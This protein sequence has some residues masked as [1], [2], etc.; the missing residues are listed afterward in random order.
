MMNQSPNSETQFEWSADVK[1]DKAANKKLLPSFALVILI[2]LVEMFILPLGKY[3]ETPFAWLVSEW[4]AGGEDQLLAGFL[5]L[6]LIFLA[7][8]LIYALYV[9]IKGSVSTTSQRNLISPSGLTIIHGHKTKFYPWSE[10]AGFHQ[11]A[12]YGGAVFIFYKPFIRQLS[13]PVSL[14]VRASNSESKQISSAL[15]IYLRESENYWP[16]GVGFFTY[17]FIILF[18]YLGY[19]IYSL[20]G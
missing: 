16:T 2:P 9:L 5:F 3:Q 20:M 6:T 13:S 12:W 11:S 7:V 10:F 14:A 17:F 4:S 1:D 19:S 18:S 8:S 15:R